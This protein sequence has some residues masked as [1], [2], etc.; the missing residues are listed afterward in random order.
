GIDS[1]MFSGLN[2]YMRTVLVIAVIGLCACKPKVH[3][4]PSSGREIAVPRLVA[5][6]Q[7][8]ATDARAAEERPPQPRPNTPEPPDNRP[9]QPRDP[10]A[11]AESVNRQ[12][13]D[14]YFEYD[15]SELGTE[16]VAALRED[17]SVLAPILAE[18]PQLKVTVEGHCDERGSAEY[19][20][21]LGDH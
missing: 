7:A 15:R 13:R 6:E 10:A 16:A 3:P 11:I 4:F 1:K 18:F 5:P 17:A 19:N 21:G 14:A 20:L 9:P 8:T 12:L 2:R